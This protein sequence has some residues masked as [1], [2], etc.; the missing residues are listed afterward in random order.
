MKGR[1]TVA[2]LDPE[3][4][5]IRLCSEGMRAEVEGRSGDAKTLFEQA[6]ER[7]SDDYE[8]CVAAHYLARHQPTVADELRWNEVC[9][10][11]A[12]A[13]ADARVAAF[14]PS[15]HACLARCHRELGDIEKAGTHFRL[16]ADHLDALP[17][18][19]YVDWLR[20]VVAEGLR[21][22]G[23]LV[24]SPGEERVADLLAVLCEDRDLRSL[25]LLLPAFLGHTGT[26]AD[27]QRLVEAA[28]QL[29]AGRRLSV[30]AQGILRD[31][32]TALA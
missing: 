4:P 27:R 18:G 1:T 3:N 14:Y 10:E 16:A 28:H 25:A 21:D 22:T 24:R 32:L 26:A 15:L 2:P 5:V 20:Y 17:P 9:L 8:A 6:W 29:H 12:D 30:P 11:R 19:S 31:A 7:A 23:V 13:V